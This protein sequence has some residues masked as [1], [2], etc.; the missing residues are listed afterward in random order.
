M[1]CDADKDGMLDKA[2]FKSFV[3]TMNQNGVNRGLKNRETDDE[4]I[5]LV[6]P[7]FQG[8]NLETS[9]VTK[10]EILT[11]LNHINNA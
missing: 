5:D 9:G 2:E 11:I 1:A 7:C 3:S 6:Y 4:F 10:M 8:F